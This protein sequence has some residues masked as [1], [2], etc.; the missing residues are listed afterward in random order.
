MPKICVRSKTTTNY[1]LRRNS[2][3]RAHFKSDRLFHPLMFCSTFYRFFRPIWATDHPRGNIII[4]ISFVRPKPCH[5]F[6]VI[7]ICGLVYFQFLSLKVFCIRRQQ[8]LS[9]IILHVNRM[10]YIVPVYGPVTNWFRSYPNRFLLR[11]TFSHHSFH[12]V[13]CWK[14][15][16]T[17]HVHECSNK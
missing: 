7:I 12:R 2:S 3:N 5:H 14:T 11:K 13:A 15:H 6:P 8:Y 16:P 17:Q 4:Y 1:L 10:H 9:G